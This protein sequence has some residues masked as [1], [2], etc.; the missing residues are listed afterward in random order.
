MGQFRDGR[1]ISNN[2]SNFPIKDV[3]KGFPSKRQFALNNLKQIQLQEK[4]HTAAQS[5]VSKS[6]TSVKK[7]S[8][9]GIANLMNSNQDD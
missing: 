3:H 9:V 6:R 1:S 8:S 2:S 4:S 7:G 5:E